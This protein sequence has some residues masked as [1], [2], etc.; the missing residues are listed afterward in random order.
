MDSQIPSKREL[1]EE[2]ERLLK[3]RVLNA[4]LDSMIDEAVSSFASAN[5]DDKVTK[6]ILARAEY[7]AVRQFRAN[8]KRFV[9]NYKV[10]S[11]KLSE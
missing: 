4:A 11:R 1:A 2:A 6:L 9:T 8:L 5:G 3:N 10:A 7:D